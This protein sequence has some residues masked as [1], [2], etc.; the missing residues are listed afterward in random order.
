VLNNRTGKGEIKTKETILVQKLAKSHIGLQSGKERMNV[1]G[2]TRQ[3]VC[4]GERK[5]KLPLNAGFHPMI[6]AG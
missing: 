4:F 5:K 2:E 3:L 1:S 6:R